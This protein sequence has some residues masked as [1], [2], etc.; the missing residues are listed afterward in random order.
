LL[1]FLG[2]ISLS[3][4]GAL[5]LQWSLKGLLVWLELL[6]IY[7]FVVNV[8]D[9]RQVKIIVILILFA[10]CL[11][12]LLGFYQFF[13]RRG[14]EGFLLFDRF[15]R[16]YG[17]FEQPNPYGGYLALILP[18]ALSLVLA[19]WRWR[20]FWSV[21]IWALAGLSLGL[22]GA[23]L[24]MSWSRGAWLGFLAGVVLV[25]LAGFWHR[26]FSDFTGGALAGLAV[27][28]WARFGSMR[29]AQ[30]RYWLRFS[31]GWLALVRGWA[32]PWPCA[33]VGP[34]CF[35]LFCSFLASSSCSWEGTVYFRRLSASASRIFCLT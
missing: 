29:R 13:G 24:V 32:F 9:R 16:A 30:V 23:A 1:I 28:G 11:E 3:L 31:V 27:G 33:V 35:W 21:I 6:A 34:G 2:V 15:I 12:A 14:P 8:V 26:A 19:R 4:L 10:G 18:L 5:S 17:T 7:L 20:D 25:T 22:M